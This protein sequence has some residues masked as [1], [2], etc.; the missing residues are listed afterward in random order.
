VDKG[1][2]AKGQG[3]GKGRLGE[4]REQGR[5]TGTGRKGMMPWQVPPPQR[6]GGEVRSRA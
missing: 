1:Q 2:R 3:K 6:V 5:A 4:E